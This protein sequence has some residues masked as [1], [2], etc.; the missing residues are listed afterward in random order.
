MKR[1]IIWAAAAAL[2]LSSLFSCGE[3]LTPSP[4]GEEDFAQEGAVLRVEH[5]QYDKSVESFNYTIENTGEEVLAFGAEYAVEVERNGVWYALPLAEDAGWNDV[6]YTAAPGEVWENA[7]SFLPYRYTVSDGNYRLI[8][9]IGGRRYCAGFTIGGGGDGD[10][11]YGYR[12]LERLSL[13]LSAGEIDC[14]VRIDAAG[15]AAQG[16][17]ERVREFLR[18]VSAGTGDMLRMVSTAADGQ[19]VI[20]DVIYENGHFLFRRDN[21]R[22]GGTIEDRR[23][24]FLVT[25]GEVVYLSDR[26][27]LSEE[28]FNGRQ[29]SAGRCVL[30]HRD[31]FSDWEAVTGEVEMMTAQ[32]LEDSMTLA[33]FWSE[34]GSY[35]VDLSREGLDY[36]VSTKGYGMS[37]TITGCDEGAEIVA[38]RWESPAQLR[39]FCA[40]EEADE[41]QRMGWYAVFDVEQEKVVVQ[42]S[43]LLPA[44]AAEDSGQ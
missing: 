39:L 14:D 2:L 17:E 1:W 25:D 40:P 7:F 24:S 12:D 26:A 20:Y 32:R 13:N 9:E 30:L 37:R 15:K 11:R 22:S 34:D 10:A 28:R 21:R 33:R 35:W 31:W 5:E 23:Y 43:A 19:P 16:G 42:G 38:V 3:D 41:D 27:A 6:S 18:H 8:K 29:I 36:T 4:Y 44:G